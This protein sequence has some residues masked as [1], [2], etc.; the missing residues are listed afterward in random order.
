MSHFQFK[1]VKYQYIT[2]NLN[3]QEHLA[4]FYFLRGA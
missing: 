4:V 3:L 2:F 1:P